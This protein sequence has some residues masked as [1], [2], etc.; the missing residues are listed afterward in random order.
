[1]VGVLAPGGVIYRVSPDGRDWEMMAHGFRNTYDAAF[2]A[3]GELFTY[4]ADME[5]DLGTPWYRPTRICHVTSGA[6]FGWRNGA[7]KWPVHTPDSLPAALDIGPGSPTGITFGHG[8]KF[9]AR[10]RDA[11]FAADWTFGRIYAV[12]LRPDGSSVVAAVD[13][14]RSRGFEIDVSGRV[15]NDVQ[16]A[17][18]WTY[19]KMDDEDGEEV[20]PFLPRTLWR[21]FAT[22][23]PR[24]WVPDLT[25]GAG[26][27]WQSGTRST[28]ASPS[29]AYT[30]RQGGFG[31]LSL[32]ARYQFTPQLS[33]QFNANN[34][35]DKK[36]YVLDEFDNTSWGAPANYAVTMR[37]SY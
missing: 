29:G 33:L 36:F 26:F 27:N 14:V 1:M 19:F 35:L 3:A 10:Y 23:Q 9:P 7:G 20:R 28:I 37:L 2:N 30:L 16:L 31:Q 32:M 17:F 22:W 18:G 13:G 4:D 11:L 24:Q 5:W 12:H 25:L 15:T 6:E 21:L 8:T 34:I